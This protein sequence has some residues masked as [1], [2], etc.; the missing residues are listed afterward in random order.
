M[1]T[2]FILVRAGHPTSSHWWLVLLVPLMIKVR[3]SGYKRAREGGEALK[4]LICGGGGYRV[5]S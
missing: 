4:S 5:E 1:G 3:S 2:R